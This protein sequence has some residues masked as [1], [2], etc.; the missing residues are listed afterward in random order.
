[1]PVAAL[2]SER[3]GL[4][5]TPGALARLRAP[6]DLVRVLTRPWD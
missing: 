1:V 4:E 3:V 6:G 5:A 2:I